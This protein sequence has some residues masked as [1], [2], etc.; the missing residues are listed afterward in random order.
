MR[1]DSDRIEIPQIVKTK[2]GGVCRR[3]ALLRG[4][5]ALVIPLTVFLGAMLLMI[6]VD[7]VLEVRAGWRII[8]SG[9]ALLAV[10]AA[11][12]WGLLRL[13]RAG[14]TLS[15]AARDV[16]HAVP[17]LGERWST[18]AELSESSDPLVMKGAPSLIRKVS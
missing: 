16:D 14:L 7:W 6:A 10:T 5:E 9:A 3:R 13:A 15:S 18:I 1:N 17:S 2:L 8:T 11:A 12:G 4:V